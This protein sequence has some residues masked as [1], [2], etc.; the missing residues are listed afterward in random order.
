[1]ARKR[2]SELTEEQRQAQRD[3]D[4]ARKRANYTPRQLFDPDELALERAKARDNYTPRKLLDPD[5][6]ALK[7]EKARGNFTPRERLSPELALEREKARGK[8]ITRSPRKRYAA[9]KRKRIE[10]SMYSNTC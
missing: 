2:R 5:E 10:V 8:S 6:L 9:P 7:R 1:M 3:R 4:V